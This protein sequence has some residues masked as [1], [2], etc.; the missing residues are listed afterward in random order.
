MLV[1]SGGAL[2]TTARYELGLH[3]DST[4]LFPWPTFWINIIGAFLLGVLVTVVLRVRPESR[5]IR[6]FASVGVLGGFTTFSAM[7][8]AS[9][10]LA[11]SGH[12]AVAVGYILASVAAGFVALALGVWFGGLRYPVPTVLRGGPKGHA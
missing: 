7:N 1:G 9:V 12:T 10:R 8:V 11:E 3:W 6:P 4:G 2:G 5:H